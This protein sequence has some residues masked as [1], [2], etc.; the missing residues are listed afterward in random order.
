MFVALL[1]CKDEQLMQ[2][3]FNAVKEEFP[4]YKF[5]LHDMENRGFQ[6]RLEGSDLEDKPV[7]Y[8]RGFYAARVSKNK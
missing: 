6:L 4:K 2:D 8:C 1:T 7:V 3:M 5:S